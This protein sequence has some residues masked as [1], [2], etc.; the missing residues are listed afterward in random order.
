MSKD[1]GFTEILGK[2]TPELFIE[3]Y[4]NKRKSFSMFYIDEGLFSYNP[5]HYKVKKEVVVFLKKHELIKEIT[6]EELLKMLDELIYSVE[7]K[8]DMIKLIDNLCK[9]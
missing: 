9:L 1:K 4:N 7:I 3:K 8:K 2:T 6:M 5:T